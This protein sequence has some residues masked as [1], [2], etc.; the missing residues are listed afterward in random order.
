MLSI[1]QAT[2]PEVE[3]A[4]EALLL[5][6]QENDATINQFLSQIQYD[7]VNVLIFFSHLSVEAL[8]NA[9]DCFLPLFN[10]FVSRSMHLYS[11]IKL[12]LNLNRFTNFK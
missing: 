6:L 5:K 8:L 9:S 11:F 10:R 12:N 1:I 2:E 4:G 3:E 7:E